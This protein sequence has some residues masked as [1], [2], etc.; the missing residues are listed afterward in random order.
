MEETDTLGRLRLGRENVVSL[1][2]HEPD[3]AGSPFDDEP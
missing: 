3:A 2:G 1:A